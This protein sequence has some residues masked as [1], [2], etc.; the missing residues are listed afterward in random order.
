MISRACDSPQDVLADT[1]GSRRVA[2]YLLAFKTGGAACST[3]RS[4]CVV[5]S[6]LTAIGCSFF[7]S[8]RVRGSLWNF[9]SHF[10]WDLFDSGVSHPYIDAARMPGLRCQVQM[11][12]C[13]HT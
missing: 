5:A 1:G 13:R 9:L 2:I 8:F 4:L 12:A 7:F 11:P 10:G 6:V 3:D